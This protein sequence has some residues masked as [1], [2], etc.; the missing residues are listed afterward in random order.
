MQMV[1]LLQLMQ[2]PV[3]EVPE[4]SQHST[5]G[6]SGT[7][8]A[9]LEPYEGPTEPWSLAETLAEVTADLQQ[10]KGH[11]VRPLDTG[12]VG[13]VHQARHIPLCD[14]LLQRVNEVSDPPLH[15][16]QAM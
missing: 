13:R 11:W 2:T 3:P 12:P 15:P 1:S 4:L 7:C 14:R 8:S 9:R 5:W 16:A 10:A 6:D